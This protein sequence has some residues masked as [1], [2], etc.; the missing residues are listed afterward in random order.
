M[1]QYVGRILE[2]RLGAGGRRLPLIGCPPGA[3][4]SPGR[5]TLAYAA[6]DPASQLAEALFKAEAA[7]GGFLA[8]S[9]DPLPPAW[10]LGAELRL[11]GPLGRGFELPTGMRNLA[12]AAAGDLA[13]RLLPLIDLAGSTAL[14]T[15]LPVPD[16]P[17]KVEVQPLSALPD[18]LPWADFTAVDI[19][20]ERYPELP[21]L[22]K[23]TPGTP[24]HPGQA[25]VVSPMPC[26]GLADCGVCALKTGRRRFRLLCK[27]GP[28][29]RL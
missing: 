24:R 17:A 20:L 11:R 12:L 3:V 4:P 26:G 18:A 16:L 10:T 22:L 5:Y 28:V 7:E 14:F 19:P 25:L 21:K 8:V 27:D 9:Q 15:D 6:E 1:N 29:I 2:F 23:R 13:V